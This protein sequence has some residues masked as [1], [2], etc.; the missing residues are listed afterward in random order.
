MTAMAAD[1]MP[2]SSTVPPCT[3]LVLAETGVRLEITTGAERHSWWSSADDDAPANSGAAV[4]GAGPCDL[5]RPGEPP[6]GATVRV[7]VAAGTPLRVIG[8]DL[9]LIMSPLSRTVSSNRVSSG[10]STSN[11]LVTLDVTGGSANLEGAATWNLVLSDVHLDARCLDGPVTVTQQAGSSQISDGDGNLTVTSVDGDVYVAG[12]S[13]PLHV[14]QRGGRFESF[15]GNGALSLTVD[16]GVF[17]LR[18]CDGAAAKLSLTGAN[19]LLEGA[20]FRQVVV[21]ADRSTLEASGA[22]DSTPLS[23]EL[24]EGSLNLR[25]WNG[26]VTVAG[27]ASQIRIDRLVGNLDAVI[28]NE[29]TLDAAD[30]AGIVKLQ[31]RDSSVRQL[32][33]TVL[34][35]TLERSSLTA[36]VTDR[37]VALRAR[38][39]NVN[40]DLTESTS[41]SLLELTDGSE[42]EIDA[43][44]PG[45][46]DIRGLDQLD[47][48]HVSGCETRSPG[49]PWG[50]RGRGSAVGG[51]PSLII[52]DMSPDSRASVNGQSR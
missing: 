21:T 35:A 36:E 18:E 43:G 10:G 30:V 27:S 17:A 46:V 31:S 7:S 20:S 22:D 33:A 37:V 9:E 49:V 24:A 42:V 15:E 6:P 44:Q 1:P 2:E 14:D 8:H 25:E 52:L 40:L 12:H 19:G 51:T 28:R 50:R 34:N 38:G 26:N 29:S 32:R 45:R 3:E 48:V 4:P 5:G 47:P 11:P 39:S 13:G 16:A 23:L 41:R